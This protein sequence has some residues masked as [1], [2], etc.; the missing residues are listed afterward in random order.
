MTKDETKAKASIEILSSRSEGHSHVNKLW[1]IPTMSRTYSQARTPIPTNILTK[2]SKGLPQ[3]DG[4][5]CGPT[6]WA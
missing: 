5:S 6:T 3:S 2:S 4:P 1:C